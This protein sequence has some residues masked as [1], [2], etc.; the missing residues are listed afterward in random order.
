MTG[1]WNDA[2][3]SIRCVFYD[4]SVL[5]SSWL[6]GAAY[7]DFFKTSRRPFFVSL[8]ESWRPFS[9]YCSIAMIPSANVIEFRLT[10]D[11]VDCQR[12]ASFLFQRHHPANWLAVE[13]LAA[14]LHRPILVRLPLLQWQM[15]CNFDSH[16]DKNWQNR[17]VQVDSQVKKKCVD[18]KCPSNGY[19][20]VTQRAHFHFLPRRARHRFAG[21]K[22]F[23]RVSITTLPRAG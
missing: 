6:F 20:T 12:H 18:L 8:M 21:A 14:W 19:L 11:S 23:E 10:V 17:K 9:W 13:L 4:V 5:H 3:Q 15:T 2:I 1:R 7:Y 16:G 22:K